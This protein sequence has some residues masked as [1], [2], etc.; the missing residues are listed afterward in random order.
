MGKNL[1]QKEE[2]NINSAAANKD[3]IQRLNFLY[4][5]SVYLQS[6]DVGRPDGGTPGADNR[7]KPR[8]KR[9]SQKRTTGDL[10]REYIQC[11][12]QVAQKTTVKMCVK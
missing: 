10:S 2:T 12:R 9:K 3:I 11:M 5:A 4:Q 7:K 6:L 1:K 8:S